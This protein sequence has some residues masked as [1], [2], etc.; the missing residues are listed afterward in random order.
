VI[1]RK[2]LRE[3]ESER[4]REEHREQ[5]YV[6]EISCSL[7]GQ[8]VDEVYKVSGV[9]ICR[10]CFKSILQYIVDRVCEVFGLSKQVIDALPGRDVS[11]WN[12][13]RVEVCD[14]D[15]SLRY[16]R[17]WIG[18]NGPICV[19]SCG[20]VLRSHYGGCSVIHY[21]DKFFVHILL[22]GVKVLTI[23]VDPSHA[24]SEYRRWRVRG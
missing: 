1:L 20:A 23:C 5:R 3:R 6:E 9:Y 8:K 18:E 2:L 17:E 15:Q 7:C 19:W 24:L 4:G 11:S 16:V 21:V 14:L 22:K 12:E 10:M 13:C